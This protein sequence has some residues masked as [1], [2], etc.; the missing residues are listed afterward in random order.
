MNKVRTGKI[1]KSMH[2]KEEDAKK[3]ANLLERQLKEK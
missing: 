1:F 2:G 3:T